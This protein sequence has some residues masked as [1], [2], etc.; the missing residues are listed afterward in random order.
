MLIWWHGTGDGG[1]MCATKDWKAVPEARGSAQGLENHIETSAPRLLLW[2]ESPPCVQYLFQAS[3]FHMKTQNRPGTWYGV[4]KLQ[5]WC[6]E[7]RTGSLPCNCERSQHCLRSKS[8]NHLVHSLPFSH[9][10]ECAAWLNQSIAWLHGIC[11]WCSIN[12]V[13]LN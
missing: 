6:L 13:S 5:L 4:L 9:Q 8:H 3:H 11:V 10:P 7:K 1:M 12:S 2:H